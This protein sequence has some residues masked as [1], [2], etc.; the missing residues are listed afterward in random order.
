MDK[1]AMYKLSY[2]LYVVTTRNAEKANGC[3]VNTAIQAASTPNQICVCIN[4]VNY[5]HDMLLKTGVF[6]V[7]VLSRTAEFPLYERFGFQSGREVDKFADYTAY[8]NAE[9]GVPYITEGTNAYIAVKVTQTVDLGSHTMFIGEVTEMEVLSEEPS[10]NYE[11]YQ[12][13]VKPKP[14]D[15]GKTVD[16]QTVWRCTICGYEYVGEELP[17]DFIC[18]LCKHPASDFEK[19]IK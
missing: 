18:P 11:Y 14:V 19:V 3:I 8:K 17:E 1:K 7:S 12:E 2:G 6:N 5:T 10:A 4:K 13:N 15:T 16:G 9:N